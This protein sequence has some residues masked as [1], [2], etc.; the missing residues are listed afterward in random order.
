MKY[1]KKRNIKDC[2]SLTTQNHS[3]KSNGNWNN[4][5]YCRN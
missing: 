4:D 3:K 1:I 2:N 5:I